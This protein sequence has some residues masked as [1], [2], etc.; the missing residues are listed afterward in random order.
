MVNP[1]QDGAVLWQ[2]S[3]LGNLEV[4]S[5]SGQRVAFPGHY[6]EGLF[7]AL[8]MTPGEPQERDALA[9]RLWPALELA[10]KR[11][12]FRQ[13]L[14]NLRRI[15]G[16]ADDGGLLVQGRT[17]VAVVAERVKTDLTQFQQLVR[18]GD[19]ESLRCAVALYR[20]ELLERY[21]ELANGKRQALA[22]LFEG[23]LATLAARERAAGRYEEAR[24][25]LQK[26]L[27]RD[28]LN[29]AAHSELMRLY[30][31]QGQPGG[32]HRQWQQAEASWHETLHTAPPE[33]LAALARELQRTSIPPA[34]V[35][36]TL[37]VSK[38]SSPSPVT[39]T[40]SAPPTA[41]LPHRRNPLLWLLLPI[42]LLGT[43]LWGRLRP[44]LPPVA[45]RSAHVRWR[46]ERQPESPEE[47]PN[48]EGMAVAIAPVAGRSGL[49]CITGLVETT[50]EDVDVLTLF[51][52]GEGK[53][54]RQVRYSG[55]GHDC[56][57]AYA[58]VAD[59]DNNFFVAGESYL[60]EAPGRREGWRLLVL[61]YSPDGA[62]LWAHTG[63]ERTKN[64]ERHIAV[65]P[66]GK[67]GVYVAGTALVGDAGK[68]EKRHPLLLH[69]AADGNP[70]WSQTLATADTEASLG[71]LCADP[72]GNAYFCAT[73][74]RQ[75]LSHDWLVASYDSAGHLRW[76]QSV[77][78]P[79]HGEDQSQAI[80][81][82][83]TQVF[84]GGTQQLTESRRVLAL[85]RFTPNGSLQGVSR[86]TQSEPDMRL[87][88]MAVSDKGFRLALAGSF[89]HNDST[90]A[91]A[92]AVFDDQGSLRWHQPLTAPTPY[93]SLSEPRV[94]ISG[95]GEVSVAAQLSHNLLNMLHLDSDLQLS[96]FRPDGQLEEVQH[97]SSPE[98]AVNTVNA[99]V[100]LP[101]T[102]HSPLLVCHRIQQDRNRASLQ[103]LCLTPSTT[104]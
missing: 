16:T 50:H 89:T 77:D 63:S 68:D 104:P 90:A 39:A 18:D 62:L 98:H 86:D 93:R 9:E 2:V 102:P 37:A 14:L 6:L 12:R 99:L 23:T 70:L 31:Q 79:G 5:P 81:F 60:P 53:L 91:S 82:S 38:A 25:L 42:G 29:L 84:V 80:A 83:S 59:Q 34:T 87:T 32:V 35:V 55:P 27:E 26:L 52:T 15:V 101:D 72:E 10:N 45:P 17:T 58:V 67:G 64:Q 56:D 76:Q 22:E 21:E 103:L 3:L 74:T 8:C 44:A 47:K 30:A 57:R 11:T 19:T 66:D 95:A 46:Y 49:V 54:L 7:A 92:V 73:L 33:A 43:G 97:F 65:A 48:S 69:F 51:L 88:S 94:C 71:A 61:K 4:R 1:E 28:A 100:C 78:G 85:A 36:P 75:G 24:A 20:G 40:K 13:E 41:V 96:R